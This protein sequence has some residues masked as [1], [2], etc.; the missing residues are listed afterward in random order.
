[1]VRKKDQTYRLCVDYRTLN[2]RTV[3]DAY[4]LPCIQDTL[5]TLSTEKWFNTLD[6]VSGYW[7]VELTPGAHKAFCS[8]KGLFEWNVMPLCNAPATFQHLMDRVLAGMQWE[9][10]L[11]CLDD[12]IV[13][14]RDVVEMLDQLGQVFTRLCQAKLKLKPFKYC[15]FCQQVVYLGHVISEHG[16]ST[17]PQKILKSLHALTRKYAHFRWTEDCQQA[18]VELNERLTSAPI[19]GY[20]LDMGDLILDTDASD[21]GIGAVLSQ[22]Q[23]G[24]EN[25][26]AYG[27]CRLSQANRIIALPG[28]NS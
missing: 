28:G 21:F 4:P 24:E 6:L 26:L 23:D 20:L 1:M 7:Q 3:K 14:G 22:V 18:F 5:D 27:S 19:L 16:I 10:C 8:R 17:D 15:L 11:V 12:I 9:T 25:V 13:L 2:E